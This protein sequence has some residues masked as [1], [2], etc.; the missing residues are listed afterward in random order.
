MFGTEISK[1]AINNAKKFGTVL[2]T[3]LI[4]EQDVFCNGYFDI[5]ICHHVIEHIPHPHPG[6]FINKLKDL[7]KTGGLLVLATPDFDSGAARLFKNNYRM[8]CDKTHVTLFSSDSMHRF[9]IDNG[10]NIIDVE[11]PYFDTEYFNKQSLMRLFDV[12][13]KSPPFYGNFITFYCIKP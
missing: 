6:L 13:K 3:D 10:F 2:H 1:Y 12:Q 5:I 8:L 9:L 11:Y 7:L 4:Q